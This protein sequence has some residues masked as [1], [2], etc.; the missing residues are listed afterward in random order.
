MRSGNF[1]TSP[2]PCGRLKC[3]TDNRFEFISIQ[4]SWAV[5][6]P[7]ISLAD[8][9]A[10]MTYNTRLSSVNGFVPN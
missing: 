10:L 2:R 4:T 1:V 3:A 6:N 7:G 9:S 5:R 8:A